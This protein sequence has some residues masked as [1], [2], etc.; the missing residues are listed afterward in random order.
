ML[1]SNSGCWICFMTHNISSLA[2]TSSALYRGRASIDL[3][4]DNLL[5]KNLR[6]SAW[7]ARLDAALKAKGVSHRAASI[8]AK[9]G[10]GVVNSW[11]KEG[12]D[13]GMSSLTAVCEAAGVSLAY[14]LFG[15]EISPQTAELVRLLEENP[16]RRDGML[17]VIQAK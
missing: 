1:E 14:V 2:D 12:K 5:M 6:D 11:F 8:G 10:P 9:L 3:F 13:P 7:L 17:K 4:C 16:D 15:F